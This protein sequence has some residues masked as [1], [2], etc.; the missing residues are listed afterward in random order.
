M[1][2]DFGTTNVSDSGTAVQFSTDSATRVLSASFHARDGNAGPV[3]IGGDSTVLSSKGWEL[4]AN[5]EKDINLLD[6]QG[7]GSLP[8]STFWLNSGSTTAKCD[9]IFITEN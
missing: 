1:R 5:E 3:Y 2:P 7:A 4:S 9:F 6:F 8:P